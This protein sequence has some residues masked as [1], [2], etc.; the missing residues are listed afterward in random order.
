VAIRQ[1]L[2]WLPILALLTVL[3]GCSG[4][5]EL[6]STSFA[7]HWRS[8]QWGEHYVVVEGATMKIIYDHNDGRVMGTVDGTTF[9]GWWTEAPTRQSPADAGEVRFTLSR[10]DGQ[11]AMNGTWRYG[12]TGDFSEDWTADRIDD[13]IPAEITAKFADASMFVPHP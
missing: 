5:D 10:N 6:N 9:T 1:R 11:L 12:T 8:P 7:G 4:G 13:A 3:V 2:S